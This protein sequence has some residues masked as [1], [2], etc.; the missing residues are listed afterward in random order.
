MGENENNSGEA[1]K[2]SVQLNEIPC[3]DEFCVN[4]IVL[5]NYIKTFTFLKININTSGKNNNT[6][7]KLILLI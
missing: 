6:N 3:A 7:W 1:A 5:I 4:L 2:R